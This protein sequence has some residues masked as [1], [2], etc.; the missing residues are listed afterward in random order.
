MS[1][2]PWSREHFDLEKQYD[3]C[4]NGGKDSEVYGYLLDAGW[5][6]EGAHTFVMHMVRARKIKERM[7][8]M[9]QAA[10]FIQSAHERAEESQQR[11][12]E[13]LRMAEDQAAR[14]GVIKPQLNRN[15]LNVAICLA[16]I[17]LGAWM[18]A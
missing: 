5:T 15:L 4:E 17:V 7:E 11:A 13:A 12:I 9:G 10:D 1:E 8:S 14:A 6:P 2:N 16:V 3:L 18:T